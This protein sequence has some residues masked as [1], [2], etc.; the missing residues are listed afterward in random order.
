MKSILHASFIAAPI[1]LLG[2][3][4]NVAYAQRCGGDLVYFLRN[5][6]GQIIQEEKV[7]LRYVQNSGS[8]YARDL[9]TGNGYQVL[10]AVYLVRRPIDETVITPDERTERVKALAFRTFCGLSF[11]EIQLEHEHQTM[12]L[13]FHNLP[14]ETNFFMD[15]LPFQEGTFEIDFKSDMSLKNQKLNHEGIKT[16]GGKYFLRSA[17]RMGFLVSADNWIKT[18]AGA[19]GM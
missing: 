3:T 1:L 13:R 9:I 19:P 7:D 18:S 2:S 15:S 14:A 5:T 4:T 17:A 12:V 8:F 6:K 11:V 10:G 16:K